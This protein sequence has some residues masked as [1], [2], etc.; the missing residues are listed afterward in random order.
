MSSVPVKPSTAADALLIK[1]V[2]KT[3]GIVTRVG[4]VHR[5]VVKP[6]TM[7]ERVP[8]VRIGGVWARVKKGF[9]PFHG[10]Y[11]Y[12]RHSFYY[13]NDE[14]INATDTTL[15]RQLV[16]G[17][18]F[19]TTCNIA[20]PINNDKRCFWDSGLMLYVCTYVLYAAT[21]LAATIFLG[22]R[23]KKPVRRNPTARPHQRPVVPAVIGMTEFYADPSRQGASVINSIFEIS[24]A[25]L[26][27]QSVCDLYSQLYTIRQVMMIPPLMA[28]QYIEA[29]VHYL[30]LA[31]GGD[32][33]S[34]TGP[35][36]NEKVAFH[37]LVSRAAMQFDRHIFLEVLFN[38]Q[39]TQ[40]ASTVHRTK[41]CLTE[42][43]ATL[44]DKGGCTHNGRCS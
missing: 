38:D 11:S 22:R 25:V 43:V 14:G 41:D 35:D 40:N 24:R 21:L 23:C 8:S 36:G 42:L 19:V 3:T 34:F 16:Y 7:V 2:S 4:A 15:V 32:I 9:A 37:T 10:R 20:E 26:P 30:T 17:I 39:A 1:G 18:P 12:F 6:Q 5:G 29:T 44:V 13:I 28:L 27:L 31:F 33:L